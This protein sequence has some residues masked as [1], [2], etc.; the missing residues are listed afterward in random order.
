[1]Q[2]EIDI[3]KLISRAIIDGILNQNN[4]QR[5]VDSILKSNEYKKIFSKQVKTRLD[6][7]LFSESGKKQIDNGII[8]GIAN[9]DQIENEVEEIL[10]GDE[11]QKILGQQI[12]ACLQEIIFSEEGRKQ[13]LSKTKE[14]LENYEI[15]CDEDF[16]SEL[17]K[18]M[19]DILLMVM[20]ESFKKLS[21][22]NRQ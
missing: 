8:D 12:K 19:S 1:M 13:I 20:K 9:S 21:A 18:G 7:I 17:S 16:N 3:E 11:Y 22:S 10:E 2:I 6:E 4:I 5:E 14:Y 15:E